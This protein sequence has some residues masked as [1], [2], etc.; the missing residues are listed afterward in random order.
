MTG[1]TRRLLLS[2][3]LA[4]PA[5]GPLATTQAMA[6]PKII[7]IA[8]FGE[9]PT[10]NTIVDGFK[11]RILASGLVEGKDVVFTLDHVN[12]DTTLIPQMI[13]KIEATHPALVLTVTT[14]VSQN[15]KNQLAG[16]GIPLIFVAVT[17]PVAAGLVPARDKSDPNMT[18]VSDA[19]NIGAVLTFA[20]RLFPEAKKLGVPYNPGEANDVS[21]IELFKQHGAEHGFEIVGMGVD[22]P[23]DIQPRTAALAREVDVIYGP[24]SSL[25]Q[26]AIS[27]VAAA[28]NEAKVPLINDNT[29]LV[30]EGVIPAANGVSYEK[31]GQKAAA[32]AL[33]LLKG[34]SPADIP[35]A[36]PTAEDQAIMIS[37]KAMEAIG[38]PIPD[39]FAD[40]GCIVE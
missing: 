37:R 11:A 40:C 31:H 38:K 21:T 24:G 15:F 2:A 25:T 16:K 1:F 9:H 30:E 36:Y 32:I 19:V 27:A 22:S 5:L 10:L 35:P 8:N 29:N 34:E 18:G 6:E 33:R 12:F 17:D 7:A 28:A 39:S 14:P 23:N 3:V 13:A 4:L 26:P 20:R